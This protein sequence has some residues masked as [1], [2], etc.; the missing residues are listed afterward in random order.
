MDVALW[1]LRRDLRLADNPALHAAQ[2]AAARVLPVFVL[3]PRLMEAAAGTPR[4][5]FLMASLGAL[6]ADLRARGGRLVLGQGDP[7]EQLA[8]LLGE[9][10]AQAVFAELD[11]TPYA[12]ARDARVARRVPLQLVAGPTVQ[13]PDSVLKADGS[14]YTVF[15]AYR[16]AWRARPLPGPAS[17]LP[18][19]ER[20]ETP[21][22]PPGARF[23]S[24]GDFT[25]FPAGEAEAWRR[26][27]RFTRGARAPVYRYDHGRDRLGQ[28]ATSQLSPYLRFGALSARQAV[29]AALRAVEA[30]P[31][32]AARRA[33]EVWLDELIW[34]EFYVAILH[35][36]PLV[37]RQS[38]RPALRA[39]VWRDDPQAFEAWCE[40]RT[41]YPVVDAGMRQLNASGWMHNRA[42]MICASFLTK[43]LLID[44]RRGERYFMQRL[45]DGDPAANNGGWQWTAGTGTDAA[46]YFRVFN[47]VAQGERFDP[48]GEYVRRWAP[49]LARLPARWIHRP[50][51]APQE[52]LRACRVRPGADYPLPIVDHAWARGRALAAYRAARGGR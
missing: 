43:D 12:R 36:F 47:P 39:V 50:W 13:H 23:P 14:P 42:R 15:G 41:G 17:L 49:E 18:A 2:Q 29:V 33:A 51:Q 8:A 25:G 5:E 24:D 20:I 30:A 27:E 10:G 31:G 9:T 48:Q 32:A 35:H 26:L 45:V 37:Q 3:D 1:W 52:V 34:R 40:G 11:H 19:P 44:W 22:G 16:R 38:F 7:A 4:L 21:P 6:A 46:P 28:Q